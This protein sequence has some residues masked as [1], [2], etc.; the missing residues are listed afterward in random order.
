MFGLQVH[1]VR[2]RCAIYITKGTDGPLNITVAIIVSF[3]A[4]VEQQQKNNY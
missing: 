1:I 3:T 4:S 2:E